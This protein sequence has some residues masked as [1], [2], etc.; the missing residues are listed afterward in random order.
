M[1]NIPLIDISR[2]DSPDPLERMRVTREWDE[3]FKTWGFATITGHGVSEDLLEQIHEE[4]L[5]FFDRP[6]ADKMRLAFPGPP[7]SQGFVPMGAE[8]IAATAGRPTPADICESLTFESLHWDE[9]P[10]TNVF[11]V[12]VH[13]PNLWPED[14]ED[15]QDL[16]TRYHTTIYEL[17]GKLMRISALALELDEYFFEPYF[18]RMTTNLRFVDYPHQTVAPLPHQLRYGAHTD[19]GGFTVLRQDNAPGGLQV[20][21]PNRQW[22]EVTPR[23]GTFV[24]NTGDMIQ[25][26]TNNRWI[27]NVHRVTNPP[28]DASATT[29]RLS[30]VFFSNPNHDAA[31]SALPSCVQ[32]GE[33]AKFPPT[34]AWDHLMGKIRKSIPQDL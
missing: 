14:M 4:G 5:K 34:T 29:R 18:D 32:D 26:W 12:S 13:R 11:D 1:E 22:V 6:M 15:F 2:F 9:Q 27:S 28:L 30:V 20:L 31:I 10:S 23:P 16:V 3:V 25:R 17:V 19:F 33:L 7:R 8:V 21:G 24:V